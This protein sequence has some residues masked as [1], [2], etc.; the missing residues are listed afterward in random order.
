M[1]VSN[2]TYLILIALSKSVRKCNCHQI[3]ETF[4]TWYLNSGQWCES[5]REM[6]IFLRHQVLLPRGFFLFLQIYIPFTFAN[7][8]CPKFWGWKFRLVMWKEAVNVNCPSASST[9]TKIF[10]FSHFFTTLQTL[11]KISKFGS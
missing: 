7:K 11:H 8:I 10:F 1:E 9:F 6:C 3:S 2:K 5:R 4:C